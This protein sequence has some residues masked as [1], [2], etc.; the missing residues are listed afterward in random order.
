[1]AKRE[2]AG[3]DG[4]GSAYACGNSPKG[5]TGSCVAGDDDRVATY[6]STKVS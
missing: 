6:R 5:S 3:D 4:S 2:V 1:M